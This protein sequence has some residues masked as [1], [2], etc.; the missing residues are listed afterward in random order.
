MNRP[1]WLYVGCRLELAGL[2]CAVA[3]LGG[4]ANGGGSSQVH[5]SVYMG[6]GYSDPWYWGPCCN[7]VVVIG[8]PDGSRPP[9]GSGS[10]PRPEHPI[11]KPPPSTPVARPLPA[12]A[13]PRP[14]AAPRVGGGARRR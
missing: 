12:A 8:P 13:P 14:V 5:G 3:F 10:R 9:N 2:L 6:V 11:A 1:N 4:C 7:D